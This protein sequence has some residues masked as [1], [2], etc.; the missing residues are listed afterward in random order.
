[1]AKESMEGSAPSSVVWEQLE[2]H[3]RTRVQEFL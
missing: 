1:M 3:A 2:T